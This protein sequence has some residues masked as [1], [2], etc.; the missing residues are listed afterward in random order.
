M[1]TYPSLDTDSSFMS[2][3]L[4]WAIVL[5]LTGALLS[6]SGCS[7]RS[8]DAAAIRKC[9]SEFRAA[10]LRQDYDTATNYISSEL[11]ALYPD[12][13]QLVTGYFRG[14]TA[15]DLVSDSELRSDAWVEFDCKNPSTAFL[16]PHRPP[17]VGQGFVKESNGWKITVNVRPVV[18]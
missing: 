16:F 8:E 1:A 2:G 14:L 13:H 18:D 3:T 10:L 11:L 9:Y 7:R 17:T 15:P 12:H 4:T 5:L 6:G